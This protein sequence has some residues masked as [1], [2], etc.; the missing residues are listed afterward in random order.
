MTYDV[1][2]NIWTVVG[3]AAASFVVGMLWYGPVF[4]KTWMKLSGIS[5]ADMKSMPLTPVQAM[6]GGAVTA[7]LMAYVLAWLA[8]ALIL[9]S[10]SDAMRMAFWLWLGFF[11]PLTAGSWL[12]EGKPLRLFL[13]NAAHW[14]VALSA[15]SYVVVRWM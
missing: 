4:G 11:V 15:M 1:A 2:I 14:L 12:W 10:A 5:R 7:L 13:F 6:V 3:A 9:L 8:Q